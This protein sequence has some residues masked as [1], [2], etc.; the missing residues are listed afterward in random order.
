MLR[1]S[2]WE[3]QKP[4]KFPIWLQGS[5]QKNTETH[6]WGPFFGDGLFSGAR[7]S[8]SGQRWSTYA[9]NNDEFHGG[10][11][12]II[13]EFKV[14]SR[15]DSC[16]GIKVLQSPKHFEAFNPTLASRESSNC[17]RN[18]V[19]TSI[20]NKVSCWAMGI[21]IQNHTAKLW[22]FNQQVGLSVQIPSGNL[23]FLRPDRHFPLLGWNERWSQSDIGMLGYYKGK[24]IVIYMP[25]ESNLYLFFGEVDGWPSLF[26]G[27]IFQKYMGHSD[28]RYLAETTANDL[29]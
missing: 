21:P 10:K 17:R 6:S 1:A 26:M 23:V 16:G 14:N 25:I 3:N 12:N 13:F 11:Y 27:R 2:P 7:N 24:K 18:K 15:L 5:L 19:V 28:S 22:L 20:R 9:P 4:H 29:I 8:M